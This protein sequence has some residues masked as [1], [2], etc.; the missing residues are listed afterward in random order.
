MGDAAAG[1]ENLADAAA[2]GE[3]TLV[4]EIK[5]GVHR[6]PLE[7]MLVAEATRAVETRAEEMMTLMKERLLVQE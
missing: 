3:E 2:K 7:E 4:E 6:V 5:E 1:G